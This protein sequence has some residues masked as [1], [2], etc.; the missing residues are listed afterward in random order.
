MSPGTQNRPGGL[1]GR[2]EQSRE[3]R[4]GS[5]SGLAVHSSGSAAPAL[6]RLSERHLRELVEGSGIPPEMLDGV[7]TVT[8]RAEVASVYTEWW[9]QLTPAIAFDVHPPTAQTRCAF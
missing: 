5:Q 2:F 1:P 9:Q 8:A 7:R 3:R 6:N 4:A